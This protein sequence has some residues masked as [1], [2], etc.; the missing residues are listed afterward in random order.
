VWSLDSKRVAYENRGDKS[1]EVTVYFWNGSAFEEA[2]LPENLPSPDIKL[3]KDC[4]A[5]KMV[6]VGKL[7]AVERFNDAMP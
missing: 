4:G 7:G 2:S 6:K 5:V 3:P 1:G